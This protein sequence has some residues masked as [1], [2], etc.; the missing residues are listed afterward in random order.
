MWPSIIRFRANYGKRAT[1]GGFNLR[2]SRCLSPNSFSG[3]RTIYMP[4]DARV[5]NSFPADRLLIMLPLYCCE[6]HTCVT[7]RRIDEWRDLSP[8]RGITLRRAHWSYSK[9]KSIHSGDS[10]LRARLTWKCLVDLNANL[11]M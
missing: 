1:G 7:C 11:S 10:K 9:F 3:E 2:R 6:F 5:I 8:L 4:L